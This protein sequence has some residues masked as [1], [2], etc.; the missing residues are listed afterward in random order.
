MKPTVLIV[1]DEAI[2]V[3]II[4]AI[5]EANDYQ[6][7][8]AFNGEECL[9]RVAEEL[10]DV[11]LLDIMMPVMD[12][13]AVAKQLKA[14]E[15][16]CFIPVIMVTALSDVK[17]RIQA[18]EAGADDFL[19]K[20]VDKAELLARL[21]ASVK[22]KAYH[23]EMRKQQREKDELLN[24][25]LK[26]TI[27]LLVEILASTN[28]AAFSQCS[29][30]VPLT[31]RIAQYLMDKDAWQAELVMMLS[32]IVEI[33]IPK[34]LQLKVGQGELL[35]DEEQRVFLLRSRQGIKLLADIP[36]LE[37][38]ALALNYR[39]KNFDGG[40]LPRD[41]I[42][43]AD[44]PMEAR[45]IRAVFDFDHLRSSKPDEDALTL[46]RQ[47]EGCYDVNVL[48]VLQDIQRLAFAE[49]L[50]KEIPVE[51]LLPGMLLGQDVLDNGGRLIVGKGNELTS[52]MK[53]RLQNMA[54]SGLIRSTIRA[55]DTSTLILER[56]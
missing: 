17:S 20:P 41:R 31:R 11:I 13:F 55:Y 42:A 35:D 38:V 27:R 22:V 28:P 3:R 56:I 34:S 44:I 52:L 37:P 6:V 47:R 14:S 24:K 19:T 54:A 32:P 49:S 48:A 10:P 1:D 5:L 30:L 29:R 46:M 53:L 9:R 2:N 36:H 21:R 51:E 18:L 50:F 7:R 33:V 25:T 39:H 15:A 8:A 16:T 26:G 23:D 4:A 45:I 40:G 43:G 12:G